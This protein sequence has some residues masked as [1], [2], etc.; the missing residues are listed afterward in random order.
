MSARLLPR[1]YRVHARQMT[2]VYVAV[3]IG[4]PGVALSVMNLDDAPGGVK[5]LVMAVILVFFGWLVWA[6]KRCSTSAD[7]QGIRVRRFTRSRRLAWE[8]VQDIRAVPHPGAA[9]AGSGP[10]LVSYAYDSTGR[11]LRLVYV[12]DDHVD[13]RREVDALR[14]AWEELRGP[15][16]EAEP[17]ALRRM[18]R[19]AARERRTVAALMWGTVGIVVAFLVAMVLLVTAD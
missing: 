10:N 14:A 9:L 15:D 13:V 18:D 7:L 19:Q 5:A 17:P 8:D 3:G 16:W 2:A 1:E 4:T 6:S 12:D 11:R